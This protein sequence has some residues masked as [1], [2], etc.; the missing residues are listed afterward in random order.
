MTNDAEILMQW[1][2]ERAERRFD[3]AVK[4]LQDRAHEIARTAGIATPEFLPGDLLGRLAF[5]PRGD[6]SSKFARGR[7][8]ETMALVDLETAMA[9]HETHRAAQKEPGNGNSGQDKTG[10]PGK[11]GKGAQ[12]SRGRAQQGAGGLGDGG[13]AL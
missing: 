8:I 5:G 2:R 9:A 10:K 1:L 6:E 3:A 7:A 13:S 11:T 4:Q 12:A